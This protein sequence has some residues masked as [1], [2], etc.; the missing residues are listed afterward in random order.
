MCVCVHGADLLRRGEQNFNEGSSDSFMHYI[1]A[2]L[3]RYAYPSL[4]SNDIKLWL[5]FSVIV[6]F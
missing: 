3:H 2:C 4:K 1:I 5:P 6:Y